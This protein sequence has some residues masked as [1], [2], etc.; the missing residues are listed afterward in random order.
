MIPK[1]SDKRQPAVTDNSV[2]EN[3]PSRARG[4]YTF[5]PDVIGAICDRVRQG[6]FTKHACAL[7]MVSR[8]AF[9]EVLDEEPGW[10]DTYDAARAE[11][12]EMYRGAMRMSLND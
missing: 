3:G 4:R 5:T 7:E 1:D 6:T 10:R 11:G 12:S 2:S 9:Y 8:S